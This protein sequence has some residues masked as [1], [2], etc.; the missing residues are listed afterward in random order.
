MTIITKCLLALL[1][2]FPAGVRADDGK[3]SLRFDL[4]VGDRNRGGGGLVMHYPLE[5]T[6][7]G[8]VEGSIGNIVEY[9]FK[10]EYEVTSFVDGVVT[11]SIKLQQLDPVTK[12]TIGKYSTQVKV[13]SS[14]PVMVIPF[15]DTTLTVSIR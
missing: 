1:L 14:S 12:K 11:V 9:S 2:L 8:E 7:S 4:D 13:T 3:V 6:V 10:E 15:S 5:K